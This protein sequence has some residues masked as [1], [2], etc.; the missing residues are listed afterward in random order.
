MSFYV[1]QDPDPLLFLLF[2]NRE[3]FHKGG[4]G[5]NLKTHHSSL[6]GLNFLHENT[7]LS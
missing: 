7:Y 6:L 2:V 5:Q 4:G 3:L 1:V